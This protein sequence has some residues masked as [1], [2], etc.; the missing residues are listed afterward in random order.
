MLGT[1]TGAA[2]AGIDEMG[3]A[4]LSGSDSQ[5]VVPVTFTVSP[6]DSHALI[7]TIRRWLC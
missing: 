6:D 4:H 3:I 7:W 2:G 5:A 1:L